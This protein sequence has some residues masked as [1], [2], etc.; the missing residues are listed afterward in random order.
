[1]AIFVSAGRCTDSTNP[2]IQ[3]FGSFQPHKK[4]SRNTINEILNGICKII[5]QY[6]KGK[7]TRIKRKRDEHLKYI[8]EKLKGNKELLENLL[9][10]I[11]LWEKFTLEEIDQQ[12]KLTLT[13]NHYIPDLNSEN[14][15]R[16]LDDCVRSARDIRG[17]VLPNI[18]AILKRNSPDS[19]LNENH[20]TTGKEVTLLS[21]LSENNVLLLCG[22]SQCGKTHTAKYLAQQFQDKGVTIKLGSDPLAALQFLTVYNNEERLFILEDPFLDQSV[23][24]K[25]IKTFRSLMSDLRDHRFLIITSKS[26]DIPQPAKKSL[27][28][29]WNDLS[30]RNSEFL[31]NFWRSLKQG[32]QYWQLGEWTDL[33]CIIEEGLRNQNIEE[34]LQPGHLV[35]LSRQPNIQNLNFT[36]LLQ[37]ARFDI[38]DLAED[39]E[40]RSSISKIVHCAI[41]LGASNTEWMPMDAFKYVIS[42]STELPSYSMDLG[43]SIGGPTV[44][45]KFPNPPIVPDISN[46]VTNE[47]TTLEHLNYIRLTPSGI[48][49][50]HPDYLA[51]SQKIIEKCSI[52]ELEPLMAMVKRGLAALHES[53]ARLSIKVLSLLYHKFNRDITIRSKLFELA[54]DAQCKSIFP[55]VR[56]TVLEEVI[57]WLSTLDNNSRKTAFNFHPSLDFCYNNIQWHKNIPWIASS[58][59]WE[60]AWA[61]PSISR[62]KENDTLISTLIDPDANKAITPDVVWYLLHYIEGNKDLPDTDLALNEM[63]KQPYAFIR[64]KTIGLLIDRHIGKDHLYIDLLQQETNPGVMADAIDAFFRNWYKANSSVRKVIFSWISEALHE[65]VFVAVQCSYMLDDFGDPDPAGKMWN[66]NLLNK[67][68]KYEVWNLWANIYAIYLKCLSGKPYRI[69]SSQLCYTMKVALTIIK[70]KHLQEVVLSWIEWVESQLDHIL[71]EPDDLRVFDFLL[72]TFNIGTYRYNVLRNALNHIDTYYSLTTMQYMLDY[73]STLSNEEKELLRQVLHENRPDIRWFRVIAITN[74]N[75]P[76]EILHLITSESD[77][78][79][80]PARIIIDSLP[81][82]LL[83]DALHLY[84]GTPYPLYHLRISHETKIPWKEILEIIILDPN[85]RDFQL[86]LNEMFHYV[87]CFGEQEWTEPLEVWNKLCLESDIRIRR[88]LFDI[89]LN[90][91]M[92]VNN[93]RT[94]GFW[95]ILIDTSKEETEKENFTQEV[96]KQLDIISLNIKQLHE[97]EKFF[98]NEFWIQYITPQLKNEDYIL[99]LCSGI[100]HAALHSEAILHMESLIN[101]LKNCPIRVFGLFRYIDRIIKDS[102]LPEAKELNQAIKEAKNDFFEKKRDRFD[103]INSETKIWNW[104]FAYKKDNGESLRDNKP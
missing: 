102:I 66:W 15:I 101:A 51:T 31:I 55:I 91:S 33:N 77:I 68:N 72:Q 49:Y 67:I 41:C 54:I 81:S 75:L 80:N 47:L 37:K 83:S 18:T 23:Y 1:M 13:N 39:L 74:E 50:T 2:F 71:L 4:N 26:D 40:N 99:S 85:H 5:A 90:Q 64:A 100:E 11:I 87:L 7:D 14:I 24:R 53:T 52:V 58:I 28:Y 92:K 21:Q 25:N 30:I 20:I 96:I 57:S 17:D 34:L 104:N 60:D 46:E 10:R 43:L 3:H 97:F 48:Q 6:S 35:H 27:Q 56:D 63:M 61:V 88:T 59:S 93:P 45:Q 86:A 98:G 89:L 76:S 78:L 95:S 22:R 9:H 36:Q 38:N 62:T 44:K 82:E 12:L 103:I 84:C 70:K 73:W 42:T 69:N 32:N 65:N 29:S 16:Q 8:A 19:I 94:F 79:S